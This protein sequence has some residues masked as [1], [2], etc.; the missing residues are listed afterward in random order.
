M[1]PTI[2]NTPTAH[3]FIDAMRPVLLST[4]PF[5]DGCRWNKAMANYLRADA[6]N[7]AEEAF[8][9]LAQAT[10]ASDL[11]HMEL[12]QQF[13]PGFR[14]VPE[15]RAR[16]EEADARSPHS[17]DD[18]LEVFCRP[19]WNA[20]RELALTPAPNLAAAL[21]KVHMIEE[22]EVWNDCH[23]GADPMAIVQDDFARLAGRNPDAAIIKAWARRQEAY[24]CYNA[25]PG[26]EE[27]E[28]A[29]AHK[30]QWAI[31]D[32]CEE[33]IRAAIAQ[34]PR[35]V[36]I[37]LWTAVAHEVTDRKDDEAA[38]RGDLADLTT[39]DSE[40]DWTVRLALAALRSLEAM[41]A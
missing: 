13:G 22:A 6:L 10:N 33:V 2:T 12:E 41:G 21:F 4:A 7:R 30:E 34:T 28:H 5:A 40:Y 8:G 26:D 9:A 25:L 27:G 39:R 17:D 18:H 31:I 38:T 23:L 36:A 24:A 15:A 35:G 32:E 20:Q 14:S 11:L 16:M 19:L 3:A 37:Q 29:A 1:T